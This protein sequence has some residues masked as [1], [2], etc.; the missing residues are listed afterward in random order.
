MKCLI[1]IKE[2]VGEK[3]TVCTHRYAGCLLKNT[4]TKDNKYMLSI[5]NS[6]MLMILVSENFL[7]ESEL[8]S[9][10]KIRYVPS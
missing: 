1:R 6:S 5:N 8:F 7:V 2:Q 10:N 4:S 9:L 3:S